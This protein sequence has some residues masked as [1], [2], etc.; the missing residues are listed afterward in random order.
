M[1]F[2]VWIWYLKIQIML[3]QDFSEL[4]YIYLIEGLNKDI[5]IP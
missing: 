5:A 2:D 4:N 1:V 3:Y